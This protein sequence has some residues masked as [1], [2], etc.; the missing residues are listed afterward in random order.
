MSLDSHLKC[1]IGDSSG[2]PPPGATH[3]VCILFPIAYGCGGG[4]KWG[5]IQ[6]GGGNDP[7]SINL[8]MDE[9]LTREGANQSG[10]PHSR[11]LVAVIVV[12]GSVGGERLRRQF[13]DAEAVMEEAAAVVIMTCFVVGCGCLLCFWFGG[14]V[15]YHTLGMNDVV[16]GWD[17]WAWK[18]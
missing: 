9:N 17:R 14:S 13:L 2:I 18:K 5:F 3:A 15:N 11:F 7:G 1:Y 16:C 12:G 4:L 8:Q 10:P 6:R